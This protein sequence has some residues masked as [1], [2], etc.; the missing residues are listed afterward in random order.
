LTGCAVWASASESGASRGAMSNPRIVY[1]SRTDATVRGEL[2]ALAAAY[3][4][5]LDCHDK[6]KAT[7]PG[8]PD[9]AEDLDNARTATEIVPE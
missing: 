9:D 8:G 7:R 3:R 1:Q 6:K 4:F 5:I 2:A